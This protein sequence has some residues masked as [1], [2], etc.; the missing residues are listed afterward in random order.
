MIICTI[1]AHNYL[2]KAVFMAET[3]KANHPEALL[4][5]C[6]PE[7]RLHQDVGRAG[8]DLCLLPSDIGYAQQDTF[9][10][11]HSVLEFSTAIKARLLA[12]L[13]DHF[14][15]EDRVL[16]LDPDV[17]VFGPF[18]EAL[19]A[20]DDHEIVVTPHHLT[21]EDTYDGIKDNV[22]RTLQCGIYNLGFL[23]LR[24]ST[25][26]S[27]FLSWWQNKLDMLCYVDFSRGLFVDQRWIDLACC[28]FPI[29]SLR[30]PGYNVA[31]WNISKRPIE[32]EGDRPYVCG[33]P[34]RFVHF[35]SIDTG[36]DLR[37]FKKYAPQGS[38]PIHALRRQYKARVTALKDSWGDAPWDFESFHSGERILS[39]V[40]IA[41][42]T[43]PHLLEET[44]DPFAESNE[45]FLSRL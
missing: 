39:D 29:S 11:R 30:E 28:F 20:L 6:Q 32:L 35:S 34:V 38:E 17:W 3:A 27:A 15:S 21:D 5:L 43:Y 24:R 8:F 25:V 12:Y 23:A 41:C 26:T 19:T 9:V 1:A 36:K 31:N 22:F 13:F 40:R 45:F 18:T 37:Y 42:R 7:R 2:A 33:R 44:S 16:Y 10:F 14:P 4:V